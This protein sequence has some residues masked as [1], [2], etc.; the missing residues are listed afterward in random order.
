VT[1]C[2]HVEMTVADEHGTVICCR[3]FELFVPKP[4]MGQLVERLENLGKGDSGIIPE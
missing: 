3:C 1:A 2:A 4:T